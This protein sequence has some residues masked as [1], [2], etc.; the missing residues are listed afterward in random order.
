[1]QYIVHVG[2]LK[3]LNILLSWLLQPRN[4]GIQEVVGLF[5]GAMEHQGKPEGLP[6]T[7]Q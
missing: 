2:A 4:S 1:M 7:A 6:R 3:V 5:H